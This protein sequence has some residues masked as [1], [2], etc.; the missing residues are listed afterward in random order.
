MRAVIYGDD[1]LAR[2]AWKALAHNLIYAANRIPEISDTIVDIDN[3]MKWGFNFDLGIFETWDAIGLTQSVEKMDRDGFEVPE[4][5]R[6]M[7]SAGHNSFYKTDGGK[8]MFYDFPSGGYQDVVVSP[9]IISLKAVKGAQKVIK[10]TS[11]GHPDRS[12]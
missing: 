11:I 12:G 6:S 5:I 10:S 8:V 9:N 1:K 3:A 7:I 4:T 2:F